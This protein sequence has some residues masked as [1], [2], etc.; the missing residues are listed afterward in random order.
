[1]SLDP[2]KGQKPNWDTRILYSYLGFFCVFLNVELSQASGHCISGWRVKSSC[3]LNE[4][5]LV[6]VMVGTDALHGSQFLTC[7]F[8][9]GL[10]ADTLAGH[11]DRFYQQY[12]NLKNFYYSSTNLQYFKNLIKVP[13]LPDVSIVLITGS[14]CINESVCLYVCLLVWCVMECIRGDISWAA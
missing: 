11:R 13:S 4:W 10:T 2:G 8:C 3:R 6:A 5:Q 12:K 7:C 1:M 14:H 9:S